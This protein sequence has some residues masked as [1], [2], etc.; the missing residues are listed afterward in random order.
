M[1]RLGLE[2]MSWVQETLERA[3]LSE[4]ERGWLKFLLALMRWQRRFDVEVEEA[5]WSISIGEFDIEIS[6]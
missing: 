1:A 5:P 6:G 3:K 4:A 2:D